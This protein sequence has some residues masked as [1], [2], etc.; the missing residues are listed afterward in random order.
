MK[1][2]AAPPPAWVYKGAHPAGQNGTLWFRRRFHMK[3][4]VLVLVVASL[5]CACG[6][7]PSA[8]ATPSLAN[9]A[10]NWSGTQTSPSQATGG[11]RMSLV[12]SDATVS[13]T[14]FFSSSD[15]NASG[16]VSGTT[17]TNS[18]SG[19]M[20]LTTNFFRCSSPPTAFV[21][22]GAG[23]NTMTWTS[24]QGFMGSSTRD[25]NSVTGFTIA[26]S[27]TP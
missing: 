2:M 8:P 5:V 11:F 26:W 9:I 20:T 19:T 3:A 16:A 21:S 17:T 27:K 22:G 7:S 10:G 24:S 25:C 23:G 12:Q 15:G 14:W 18:F 6:S 4:T 1:N 13:G